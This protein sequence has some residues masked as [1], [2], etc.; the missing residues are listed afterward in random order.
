MNILLVSAN[1][2]QFNMPAMPLGLA[3]VVEATRNAGHH[4]TM[5]DLMFQIDVHTA[6]QTVI[7]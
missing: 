6:L 5:L 7:V 2:E 1:T 3:C 4:V